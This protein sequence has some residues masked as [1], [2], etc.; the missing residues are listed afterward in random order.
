MVTSRLEI[1]LRHRSTGNVWVTERVNNHPQ[2][3]QNHTARAGEKKEK[4]NTHNEKSA[5]DDAC[6]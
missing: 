6:W 4:E 1:A 2:V 5:F 3:H